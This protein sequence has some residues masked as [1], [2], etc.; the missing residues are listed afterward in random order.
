MWLEIRYAG[1]IYYTATPLCPFLYASSDERH[2]YGLELATYGIVAGI[3]YGKLVKSKLR[4]Y[5]SLL[6]SMI[7]GRLVWG[8]VSIIIYGISTLHLLGKC[9]WAELVKCDS[10]YYTT[11]S[12]DSYYHFSIRKSR[13]NEY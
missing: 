13:S 3:L 5:I 6:V 12:A 9:F 8:A 4:I 1:G 11:N 2:L 7:T 10:W